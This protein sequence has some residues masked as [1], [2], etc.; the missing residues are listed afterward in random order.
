MKFFLMKKDHC[1]R[2]QTP[3]RQKDK[4]CTTYAMQRYPGRMKGLNRKRLSRQHAE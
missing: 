3:R 2:Q 1:S 4:G